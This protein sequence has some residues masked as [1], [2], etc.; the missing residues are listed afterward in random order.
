[1]SIK[2][3]RQLEKLTLLLPPG[4]VLHPPPPHRPQDLAQQ[5]SESRLRIPDQIETEDPKFGM[6]N[7]RGKPSTQH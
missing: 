5:T 4:R 7:S 2:L 1:M 3:A 6:W